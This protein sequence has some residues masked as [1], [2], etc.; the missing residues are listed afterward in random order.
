MFPHPIANL[1]GDIHTGRMI[2]VDV[3]QATEWMWRADRSGYTGFD[4]EGW[5]AC[6]VDSPCDV[7]GVRAVP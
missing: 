1:T 7:R 3:E 2:E 6:T 4:V 5:D